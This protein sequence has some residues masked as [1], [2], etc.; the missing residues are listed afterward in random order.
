MFIY[1]QSDA[2]RPILLQKKQKINVS[3]D[4]IE[5]KFKRTLVVSFYC[6]EKN[7]A[8][9]RLVCKGNLFDKH[10]SKLYTYLEHPCKRQRDV[11]MYIFCHICSCCHW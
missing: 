5:L 8:R 1:S 6:V 7:M 4:I 2:M 9:E 10:M 3:A 11:K